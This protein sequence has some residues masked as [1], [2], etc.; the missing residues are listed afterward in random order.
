MRSNL[1]NIDMC[2]FTLTRMLTVICTAILPGLVTGGCAGVTQPAA[3]EVVWSSPDIDTTPQGNV[4]FHGPFSNETLNITRDN[5]PPHQYLKISFDF[6]AIRTLDGSVPM[7]NNKPVNLGPDFFR[8]GILKGPTLFYTT[9]SNRPDDPGFRVESKYQNY[10]SQVPGEHLP[11]QTGAREKNTLGYLYPWAGAPQ[12]FPSDATYQIDF[13]IPHRDPKVVVQLTGMNLQ[14]II[15]E[16]WGVANF[17]V[18]ALTVDQV[19]QPGDEE[20][21]AAFEDSLKNDSDALPRDFQTLISGMDATADWVAAHVK[22]MPIDA[23]SVT[24]LVAD[25]AADD[26][27]IARRDP[28]ASALLAVGPQIEPYLRDA[29]NASVGTLRQRLDWLL[30]NISD[31]QIPDDAV[32]RVVLATRVLEIVGTPRALQVRRQL[33]QQP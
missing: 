10:P 29:R 30:Q 5:L 21:A 16:S 14:N 15:D 27:Q 22:A 4:V 12:P 11:P 28:A 31:T 20:I 26:T 18:Q 24:R 6:L 13:V 8:L 23:Q 7:V 2:R 19:K 1:L 25:L 9:F 17:K 3:D 33:T 32:R